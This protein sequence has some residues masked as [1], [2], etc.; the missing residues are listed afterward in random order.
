[1]MGARASAICALAALLLVEAA[2]GFG[3]AAGARRSAVAPR[4][5]RMVRRPPRAPL[6]RRPA[7]EPQLSADRPAAPAA[8]LALAQAVDPESLVALNDIVLVQAETEARK[9]SG[10]LFLPTVI[11]RLNEEVDPNYRIGTVVAVGKGR[12]R[13]N[14]SLIPM[15]FKKGQR[16]VMPGSSSIG[17]RLDILI[18][19]IGMYAYRQHEIVAE[20]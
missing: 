11:D 9:T 19:S 2:Q 3:A 4:G 1:M 6:D 8:R 10:G 17:T 20:Y 16:V 15:P 12:V 5:V 7:R 13:E 14:G 18:G